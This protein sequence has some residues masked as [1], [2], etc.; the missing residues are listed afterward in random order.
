VNPLEYA[1]KDDVLV[2]STQQKLVVPR[3]YNVSDLID[4]GAPDQVN[5][6]IDLISVSVAR[7]TWGDG[8]GAV[9]QIRFLNGRIDCDHNA[10]QSNSRC[11][12]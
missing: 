7:G 4:A 8:K 9:G 3:V 12:N 11:R 2:I 5:S 10:S 6:L 1:V